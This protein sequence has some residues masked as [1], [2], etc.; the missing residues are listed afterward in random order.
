TD[1]QNAEALVAWGDLLAYSTAEDLA[2]ASYE[3]ALKI[4][5]NMPEA[6]LG[7]ARNPSEDPNNSGEKAFK[8]ALEVSPNS[9]DGHILEAAQELDSEDYDKALASTDKALAINPQSVDALSLVA[10]VHYVR[11]KTDE[12]NK[13]VQKALA[14][15]PQASGLYYTIAS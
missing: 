3:D 11:G 14:I 7:M 1:P 12:F 4:D 10:A 5:P 13:T 9:I 8:R 2:V 15:N 6:L